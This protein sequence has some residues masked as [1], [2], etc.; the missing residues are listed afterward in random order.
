MRMARSRHGTANTAQPLFHMSDDCW[1]Q[2]FYLS[3]W[4]AG[5]GRVRAPDRIRT[6]DTFF[7]REVLY[8]LSYWGSVDT[9]FSR[10]CKKSGIDEPKVN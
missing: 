9:Y 7:R 4:R 3:S 6:Y 5:T 2:T 10:R 1:L 8:P